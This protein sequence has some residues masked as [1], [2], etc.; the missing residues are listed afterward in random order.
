MKEHI[1]WEEI[2]NTDFIFSNDCW[3]T[4]NSNCCRNSF[5]AYYKLLPKKS[6]QLF[7]FPDEYEYYQSIGGVK[8]ITSRPKKRIFT[9]PSGDKIELISLSCECQGKCSPHSSRPLVCRLYPYFPIINDNNDIEGF[10]FGSVIE[11]FYENPELNHPC[12]LVRQNSKEIQ[13][14][15]KDK[16]KLLLKYPSIVYFF[17]AYHILANAL[18]DAQACKF[19]NLKDEKDFIEFFK[20][21]E[22]NVFTGN[23]FKNP[24]VVKELIDEYIKMNDKAIKLL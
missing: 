13:D 22:W 23:P 1:D 4:C 24:V 18:R 8:D 11:I 15:L 19:D 5:E 3:K 17:K 9:M 12:T 2:Y 7:F 10:E 20:Q 16:M 21:Y 6:M 14:I